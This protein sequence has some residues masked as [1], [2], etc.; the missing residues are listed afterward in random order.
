[1]LRKTHAGIAVEVTECETAEGF[2]LLMS[3]DCDIALL[4]PP[5]GFPHAGDSRFDQE[6]L[7]EEPLDL[8]VPAGHPLAQ[9]SEIRLEETADEDWIA[10]LPDSCDHYRRL[11]MYG[12]LVGFTP[13]VVHH[14]KEWTSVSAMVCHGL[15]ISMYPRLSHILPQH[16]A[17][18]VPI[19]G[20]LHPARR[21]LSCVRRGS[22]RHPLIQHGLDALREVID[23]HPALSP[24]VRA[25]ATTP[26]GSGEASR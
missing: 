9:R 17:V 6:L 3:T 12:S 11:M 20:D 8:L 14:V 22:R 19:A 2:D 1:M 24:P 4:A 7:V 26:S 23:A 21:I 10:P 18:R 25:A 15:G 5:E 13:R 16:A